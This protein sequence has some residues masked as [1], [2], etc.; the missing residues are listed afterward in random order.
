MYDYWE[1]MEL[2]FSAKNALDVVDKPYLE[3]QSVDFMIP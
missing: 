1:V 2:S 3:M